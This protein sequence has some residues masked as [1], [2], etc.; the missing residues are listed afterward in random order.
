MNI[1]VCLAPNR[2]DLAM[3]PDDALASSNVG[4][5]MILE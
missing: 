2:R 1:V 4:K 3:S 5:L